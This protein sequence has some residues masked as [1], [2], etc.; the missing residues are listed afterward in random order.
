MSQTT[1]QIDI[2]NIYKHIFATSAY[3]ARA[4][5]AM[6]IPQEIT[7]RMLLTADDK[8]I[9][10]PLIENS[11]N[12]IFTDI[13]RYHPG[14]SVTFG[15]DGADEVYTFNIDTPT[16]YPAGNGERLGRSI[17]SYIANRTLQSWYTDIKPD[18]A[19]IASTKAQNDAA[20]I[21]MLLTQRAKPSVT[22]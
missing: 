1:F 15:Q 11:V 16:N 7:E 9:I 22:D 21:Q 10:S 17:V 5:Q 14:S 2:Q 13:E 20:L 19:G 3:T 8:E 18:E 6:G 12:E 4:R